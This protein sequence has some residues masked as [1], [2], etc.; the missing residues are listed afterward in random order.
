MCS[1]V[2]P[3]PALPLCTSTSTLSTLHAQIQ[4]IQSENTQLIKR[5]SEL[6]SENKQLKSNTIHITTIEQQFDRLASSD[7]LITRGPDSIER[8]EHFSFD[9]LISDVKSIAPDV[10]FL[11]SALGNTKR[12]MSDG[13]EGLVPE[14][15]KSLV[16]L[17]TVLNARNR[18]AKG[19]QLLLAMMLIAHGTS[20]QVCTSQL[21]QIVNRGHRKL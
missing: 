6:E 19:L 11:F 21:L 2:S 4:A 20:K 10:L 9:A 1:Q 16:S 13:V 12:N 5:V 7:T 8:L 15:V 17:C 3:N 14:E 18:K